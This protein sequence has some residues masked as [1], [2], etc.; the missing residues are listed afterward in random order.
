M[1]R[2]GTGGWR[3]PLSSPARLTRMAQPTAEVRAARRRLRE[4]RLALDPAPRAAAERRS[5]RRSRGLGVFRRG[6]RVAL[7]LP[8]PGEVDLRPCLP[9]RPAARHAASTCRA[10]SAAGVAGC[11]SCRWTAWRGAAHATRSA[12]SSR[13]SAAGARARTRTRRGRAAAGR[14]R[15]PRQPA[16]HGRRATTTAR[17]GGDSTPGGAWRRP[18][19][20]GVAYACQQLPDI[21]GLAL[22]RAARPHRHRAGRHRARAAGPTARKRPMKYWLFKSEPDDLRRG[23]PRP[24]RAARPPPGTACATTRCATCCATR[25]RSAT[26]ASSTTRAATCRASTASCAS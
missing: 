1:V 2:D 23:R 20:I 3:H 6:A 5:V 26:R 13:G 22:G 19:L 25:C 18:R 8:M 16:R 12:S 9:S 15:P 14:L 21:P 7:Y 24:A 10:S 17:C 4:L 11:C